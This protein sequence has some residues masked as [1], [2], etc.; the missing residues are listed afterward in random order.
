[1]FGGGDFPDRHSVAL[2]VRELY[3]RAWRS[4]GAPA[5]AAQYRGEGRLTGPRVGERDVCQGRF[6]VV[7][8]PGEELLGV[9]ENEPGVG[10]VDG[11]VVHLA[12]V[13][14][15]IEEQ[16]RQGGEMHVFVAVSYT[17]LRAHET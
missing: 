17:H 13:P 1:M 12:R 8:A 10:R 9:G 3:D 7:H 15:E 5:I 11:E 2:C 4:L 6:V 14:G 16:R